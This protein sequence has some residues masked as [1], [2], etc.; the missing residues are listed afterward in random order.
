MRA[1]P[2]LRNRN[3]WLL[4]AAFA[5]FNAA[6]IGMGT[7]LPTFLT[8]QHGLALGPAAWIA[9]IT[10]LITI[11]SA[12]AGGV[13]SDR[14]GSRRKPYLA[15][16]A[17]AILLLPLT[18][19]VSL[20]GVIV[21]VIVTGL[22]LGVIPTNIFAGAVEAAGDPRQGGAAMAV[23]MVGQNAG[24][25]LGPVIFGTLAQSAGWPAAFLSLAGMAGLGL[26]AGWLTK[27]R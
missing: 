4:S 21:L 12:P 26:L 8:A 20:T 1:T 23:I 5:A 11:F 2:V 3:L 19:F 18:G 25:L 13:L 10:S 27:V 24:M 14:I 17:A 22:T 9:S 15:G 7:Y 16:F 6:A